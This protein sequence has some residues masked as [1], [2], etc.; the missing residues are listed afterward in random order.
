[1]ANRWDKLGNVELVVL[2]ALMRFND[3]ASGLPDLRRD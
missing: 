1:M 3:E 2:L